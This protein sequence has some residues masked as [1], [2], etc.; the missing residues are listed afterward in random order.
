MRSKLHH[1][2]L[3]DQSSLVYA[4][5]LM[6][7]P[8]LVDVEIRRLPPCVTEPTVLEHHI[9]LLRVAVDNG[10][11]RMLNLLLERGADINQKGDRYP[12]TC[13]GVA[14]HN[15]NLSMVQALLD[16]GAD[17]TITC[18]KGISL[19]G[20]ALE[21]MP[22]QALIESMLTH[23]PFAH[24]TYWSADLSAALTQARARTYT[25]VERL[26]C[27][28][29][30]AVTNELAR[31]K[32]NAMAQSHGHAFEAVC[33]YGKLDLIDVFVKHDILR[34]STTIHTAFAKAVYHGHEDVVR[35]LLDLGVEVDLHLGGPAGTALIVASKEGH[36]R[37]VRLLLSRKAR[38]NHQDMDNSTALHH[39]AR[40]G[41][42]HISQMLLNFGADP[43]L[44]GNVWPKYKPAVKC[45]Q[46]WASNALHVASLCGQAKVVRILLSHL[47][48]VKT[49]TDAL[50]ENG[51]H[52]ISLAAALGHT[53]CVRAF[54][55]TEIPLEHLYKALE[56]AATCIWPESRDKIVTM[57]LARTG[58]SDH[59]LQRF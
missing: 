33:S 2:R 50:T 55:E 36:E 8:D 15:E 58:S 13:L 57:L 53:G 19:L 28:R 3:S 43:N 56:L 51:N 41:H 30:A 38:V 42:V 22:S 35:Q 17:P 4:F 24:P 1:S 46:T 25:V 44:L 27:E 54:L 14:L 59:V 37:I 47:G 18:G 5:T 32:E 20:H 10:D 16:A 12:I 21:R 34:T 49:D 29:L 23:G 52:A 7:A 39:A 31:S 45:Y 6:G 9:S 48:P 11:H 40:S 26:L